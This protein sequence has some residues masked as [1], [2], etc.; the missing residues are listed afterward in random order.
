MAMADPVSGALSLVPAY[1]AATK[2]GDV[3]WSRLPG[4]PTQAAWNGTTLEIRLPTW[5]ME[6]GWTLVAR[7]G[8][9]VL[10]EL[11]SSNFE[12][13]FTRVPGMVDELIRLAA[14]SA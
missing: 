12:A 1:V 7:A 11:S 14:T 8:A 6:P 3:R 10:W 9:T 2:S 13:R 5:A 4:Q